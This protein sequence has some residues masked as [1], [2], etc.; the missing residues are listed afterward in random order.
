MEVSGD[1]LRTQ[2]SHNDAE[3]LHDTTKS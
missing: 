2:F 3:P 1:N